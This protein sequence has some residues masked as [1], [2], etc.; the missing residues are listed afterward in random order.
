M[1]KLVDNFSIN[2]FIL[3]KISDAFSDKIQY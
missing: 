2:E 1:K 3:K